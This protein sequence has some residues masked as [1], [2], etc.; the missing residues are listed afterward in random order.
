MEAKK[1]LV[2]I[3]IAQTNGSVELTDVSVTYYYLRFV[4]LTGRVIPTVFLN[5]LTHS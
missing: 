5:L 1:K 3:S 2:T 4:S